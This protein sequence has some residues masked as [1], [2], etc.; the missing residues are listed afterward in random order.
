[1]KN[2][3]VYANPDP[4]SFSH[5]IK[6]LVKEYSKEKGHE[7]EVRDLYAINFNPVLSLKELKD[8]E[9]GILPDEIR[10]E[11]DYINWADVITFIFPI[12][13]GIPSILKGYIDRVFA[14]DFAY[15]YTESGS[16]GL[17]E[18]KKVFLFNPM[19]SL[20]ETYENNGMDKALETTINKGIFEFSAMEVVDRKLFGGLPRANEEKAIEYLNQVK[21]SLSKLL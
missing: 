8:S 17:L 13:W 5:S 1:M 20:N 3:I 18:G 12:W 6:E 2:L 4:N 16:K 9:E 15:T 21:E 10:K 11:Q 19:G 14:Y 7:V